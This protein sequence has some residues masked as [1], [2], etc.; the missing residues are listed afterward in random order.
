VCCCLLL[1]ATPQIFKTTVA[2]T[3]HN[4][5]VKEKEIKARLGCIED[6]YKEAHRVSKVAS[7][8]RGC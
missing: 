4:D 2:A 1:I 7:R 5:K 3:E 6:K 8:G